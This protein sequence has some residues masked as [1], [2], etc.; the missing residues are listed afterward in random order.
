MSN[1]ELDRGDRGIYRASKVTPNPGP[2]A[3]QIEPERRGEYY[4]YHV[5]K[6]WIVEEVRDD[7]MLVLVTRRGK[8]RE[9]AADDPR[10]RRPSWSENLLWNR[11]FPKVVAD[12]IEADSE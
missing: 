5:G 10:L 1:R 4:R 9:V 12:V 2:R 7:G 6:F 3:E 8:K 11:K